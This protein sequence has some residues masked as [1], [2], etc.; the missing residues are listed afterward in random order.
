[1]HVEGYVFSRCRYSILVN[2]GYFD[3]AQHDKV[4]YKIYK[5]L[6]HIEVYVILSAVEMYKYLPS[7]LFM[8][9]KYLV[10]F[11]LSVNEKQKARP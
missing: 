7:F 2:I 4:F 1:M 3:S 11:V 10:I 6:R 5:C 8:V 9:L